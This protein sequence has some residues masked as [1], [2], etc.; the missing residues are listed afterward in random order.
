MSVENYNVLEMVFLSFIC[1]MQLWVGFV[2]F[3]FFLLIEY[4]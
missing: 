3:C 1:S 4:R 2:L